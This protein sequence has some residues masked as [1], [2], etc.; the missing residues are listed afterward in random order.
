MKRFKWQLQRV[1][2]VQQKQ[3]QVK[4]AQLAAIT[5][6]LKQAKDEL[7]TKKRILQELLDGLLQSSPQERLSK[8]AFFM[9]CSAAND[10]AIRTLESKI[11]VL[12]AQQREKTAEVI[13]IK[14]ANEGLQKLRSEAEMEF[15]KEQQ[16]DE[17]KELD[18]ATTIR[19]A[20]KIMMQPKEVIS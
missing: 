15:L 17:Q 11:Q 13:K 8:Q 3:E 16:Q 20:H 9:T 4:R 1:L 19:F 12:A 10:A 14:Q 6:Q 5:E 7:V 18:E 2:E